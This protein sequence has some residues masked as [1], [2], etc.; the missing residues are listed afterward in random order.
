MS[1]NLCIRP[2]RQ[3]ELGQLDDIAP[4]E[5]NTNVGATFR[6]HYG[7]PY[8]YCIGA[9]QQGQVIGCANG[10]L[11]GKTGWLGNIIVR[12]GWRGQGLG[13]ALTA[14]LIAFFKARGCN[15]LLLVAT[16]MGESI[17]RKAGFEVSSL[18]L[19]L[20]NDQTAHL[21]TVRGVRPLESDDIPAVLEI[22]RQITGEER[23]EFLEQFLA[24]GMLYEGGQG[25]EGF[26]LPRLANGLI[27]ACSEAA[28]LALLRF[29]MSR[30]SPTVV[31]PEANSTA[32]GLLR[33]SGYRVTARAPRMF[34][35]KE[36]NWR[37][38]GVYSRAA[39]Y[40]G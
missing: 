34:L 4:A 10:L 12:P 8:F 9:I 18:Y 23:A 22:D 21:K 24:G 7:R 29:K 2:L 31:V 35:G 13:S 26:L 38:E 19:F 25:V 39:G 37:P 6:L 17:Y 32:L 36:V 1:G 11:H 33:R 5:W 3:E 15:S 28:G 30:G 14:S 20:K 27:L 40:C 16:E